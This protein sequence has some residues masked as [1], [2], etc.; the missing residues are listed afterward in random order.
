MHVIEVISS[1]WI[2]FYKIFAAV[3]SN[4]NEYLYNIS[5]ILEFELY[6]IFIAQQQIVL[7][8]T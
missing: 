4:A 6:F 2:I 8:N 7:E 5:S 1:N 3:R